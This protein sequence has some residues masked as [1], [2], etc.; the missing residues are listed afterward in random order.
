MSVELDVVG[1]VAYLT[2]A[3]PEALNAFD[4][5]M[6]DRMRAC[7][8]RVAG[9]RSVRA[10]VLAGQGRSFC[11]GVDVKGLRE[12]SVRL[13]WFRAWHHMT[14]DLEAIEVP[15]IAAIHGHCLGGG[16]MLTLTADYRLAGD[17]LQVGLGAVRHGILPG[18]APKRLAGIVGAAAARRLCLF[19]EYVG[20]A[21]ALRIGLVDRVVPVAELGDGARDLAERAA[22]FSPTAMRELKRLL[23]EAPGLDDAAYAAAYLSAQ[24]R[25]LADEHGTAGEPG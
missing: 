4:G 3:R 7:I 13:D 22:S 8:A 21:E 24:E 17:D 14:A 16:L 11:T 18:S 23:R 2:M 10:V 9:D 1:P 5:P 12:G 15:L 20:A 6:I 19:G 25:C